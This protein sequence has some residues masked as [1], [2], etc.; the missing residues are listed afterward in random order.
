MRKLRFHSYHVLV[1]RDGSSTKRA[2]DK[3]TFAFYEPS[4]SFALMEDCRFAVPYEIKM[5]SAKPTGSK[6]IPTHLKGCEL[7]HES[8]RHDS[9]IF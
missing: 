8:R 9:D 7:N 2:F 4:E 3:R 6:N 5:P 1:A